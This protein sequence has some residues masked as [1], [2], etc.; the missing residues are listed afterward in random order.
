[1]SPFERRIQPPFR[2]ACPASRSALFAADLPLASV[3]SALSSKAF[4]TY[5][6]GMDDEIILAGGGRTEVSRRGNVIYRES[7]PWSP[8]IVSLLRHLEQV[9]FAACPHVVGTGF[10]ERGRETLSF[11]EGEFVHP[12]P[13]SD[14]ALPLLGS[15]LRQLHE[16]T[17]SFKVPDNAIWRGWFGR[18]LGTGPRVIGHCDTGPWNIVSHS[19]T[20]IA[21]IDWEAAGPVGIDTELAQACWL[22][23]QLYDDDI[24]ERM[25]LGSA[26]ARA[27]QVRY[28]LDGYGFSKKQRDGFF[29]KLLAFAIHDAA[30][31]A[32]EAHVTPDTKGPESL[33]AITWRT[34]SASWMLRNRPT[35]EAVL[36]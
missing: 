20:P 6:P 4:C 10:D 31:Q 12:G 15:M 1:M 21:L 18:E 24:A 11:I 17:S 34:R 32:K 8:V 19:N 5:I 33:W 26:M 7:G 35:L 2:H 30:E 23:A 13:W 22:N 16:A 3:L 36:S 14:E 27:R 9:G 28:L 29:G 25:N